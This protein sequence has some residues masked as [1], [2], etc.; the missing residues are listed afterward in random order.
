[1]S[2]L[3]STTGSNTI[4]ITSTANLTLADEQPI[5]V[6]VTVD[7]DN[8]AG[9]YDVKFWYAAFDGTYEEP[10]VWT[11]L[12]ATVTTAGSL[13]LYTGGSSRLDIGSFFN[14]GFGA[15]R[16]NIYR[17]IYRNGIGGTR[18]ADVDF[19]IIN[20]DSLYLGIIFADKVGNVGAL[21]AGAQI[22]SRKSNTG[23]VQRNA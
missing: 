1:M 23:R 9:G 18:V 19:R 12:G 10:T 5:W 20:P 11:Q 14:G 2:I 17:Y 13:S 22:R 7:A 3:L 4:T 8:G 16:C 21:G 15:W 6:K